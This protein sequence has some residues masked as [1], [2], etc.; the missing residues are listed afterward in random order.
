MFPKNFLPMSGGKNVGYK[1]GKH[2]TKHLYL[3]TTLLFITAFQTCNAMMNDD[4]YLLFSRAKNNNWNYVEK[5]LPEY[6]GDIDATNQEGYTLLHLAVLAEN[7]PCITILIK[8]GANVNI[9]SISGPLSYNPHKKMWANKV[10][11]PLH[12]AAYNGNTEIAQLL[13]N[14]GATINSTYNEYSSTPLHI[15]AWCGR[16]DCVNFLIT[17]DAIINST[18]SNGSTPAHS[19]AWKNEPLCLSILIDKGADF[20]KKSTTGEGNTPLYLAAKMGSLECLRIL[21]KKYKSSGN[22][23]LLDEKCSGDNSTAIQVAGAREKSQ[24]YWDLF[25]AGADYRKKHK[26]LLAQHDESISELIYRNQ[27]L[28][29]FIK[30]IE[31]YGAPRHYNGTKSSCYLCT[32]NCISNDVIIEL[33]TCKDAF[34]SYCFEQYAL[35][36]FL[37]KNK[38]TPSFTDIINNRDITKE[39]DLHAVLQDL[40]VDYRTL[41]SGLNWSEVDKCPQCTKAIDIDKAA[42]S[43]YK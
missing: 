41:N 29:C 2:M 4:P 21:I 13:L 5:S 30:E 35:K 9:Q 15:A 8:K 3:S 33:N 42:L 34:H 7:I 20:L 26:D 12:C 32:T 14:A 10:S 37:F 36:D 38:N 31:T 23:N 25:V 17:H 11:T 43:V 24:C 6:T 40:R 1:K 18:N 28:Q 19:A 22:N 27:P 16:A 39:K